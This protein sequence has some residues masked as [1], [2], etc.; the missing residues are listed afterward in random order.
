MR[1]QAE[2]SVDE[3]IVA[4]GLE[5]RHGQKF[6]ARLAHLA[7]I[8]VEVVNVEPIIAPLVTDERL[9]LRDLVGVVGERVVNSAAVDIEV[10][11]KILHTDARALD[12][13]AGV[14]DAPRAI[15]LELLIVE[16]G[17][18]E[19]EHEVCLVS[20]VGVLF[21]ALADSDLEVLFLEIVENVVLPE[22]RGIEID[23]SARLVSVALFD[24]SLDS[25]DELVDAARCGSY[26]LGSLD[27]EL[28]AVLKERVGVEL[29][30][31]KHGLV[32][33]LRALEHLVLA[34]VRVAREVSYVGYVHNSCNVKTCVA[35]I[36]FKHVLH[37]IAAQISDVRV[38]I[39]RRAAGVHINLACDVG[40]EF[41]SFSCK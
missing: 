40:Y 12:V 28:L 22:L 13:P 17:L 38:V 15:P 36:L 41:F 29:R 39:Y 3:R 9:T 33:S 14:T 26:D 18:C 27:V 34:R 37:N 6:T 25:L 30:D 35:E 21:N 10:L 20:L 4:L 5:Q 1:L 19:P 7:R 31:L 11:A 16:L 32:L 23:I 8:G 24:Q 2:K